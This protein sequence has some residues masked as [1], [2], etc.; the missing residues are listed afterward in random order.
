MVLKMYTRIYIYIYI[1]I[2]LFLLVLTNA[3][4][5]RGTKGIRSEPVLHMCGVATVTTVYANHAKAFN[6]RV[7]E[8]T[9]HSEGAAVPA[10]LMN[11]DRSHLPMRTA[12]IYTV[13]V[14]IAHSGDSSRAEI[15]CAARC[16]RVGFRVTAQFRAERADIAWIRT[17]QTGDA[18]D[19]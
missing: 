13:H 10:R 4:A 17:S 18:G 7:A 2:I 3:P 19:I 5:A 15:T 8:R 1:Y 9:A 11:G 14:Q 12:V 6:R 16:A